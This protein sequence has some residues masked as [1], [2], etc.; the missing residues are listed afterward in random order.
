MEV[1]ERMPVYGD[2]H[3]EP[4]RYIVHQADFVLKVGVP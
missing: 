2:F 4:I 3:A 1:S